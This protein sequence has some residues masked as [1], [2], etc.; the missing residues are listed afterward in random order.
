MKNL[1]ERKNEPDIFNSIE[2]EFYGRLLHRGGHRAQVLFE[3]AAENLFLSVVE[4][5]AVPP[6]LSFFD[7]QQ[8]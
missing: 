6:V 3:E 4:R 5:G 1:K 8:L 2:Y 7:F